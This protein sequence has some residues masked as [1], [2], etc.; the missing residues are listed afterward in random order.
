MS[1]PLLVSGNENP[2]SVHQ[3]DI[4]MATPLSESSAVNN[5]IIPQEAIDKISCMLVDTFSSQIESLVEKVTTSVTLQLK[6]RIHTLET[7]AAES[8]E[9]NAK[10]RQLV[11]DP[12]LQLDQQ[13]QYSRMRKPLKI[14]TQSL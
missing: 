11:S 14:L 7:R 3:S 2:G 4:P 9:E 8:A 10:L 13:E 6:E 5:I 12:E 1:S